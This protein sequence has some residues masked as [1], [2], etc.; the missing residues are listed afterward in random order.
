MDSAPEV[1]GGVIG[2]VSVVRWVDRVMLDP[3]KRLRAARV[4]HVRPGRTGRRAGVTIAVV[5]AGM[6]RRAGLEVTEGISVVASQ[7]M[8]RAEVNGASTGVVD[9]A[10]ADLAKAASVRRIVD[11]TSA[12]TLR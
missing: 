3:L 10:L 8:V 11:L 9:H 2:A 6:D 5:R 1:G 4:M 7:V 12:L